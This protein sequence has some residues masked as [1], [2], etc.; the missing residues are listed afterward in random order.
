MSFSGEFHAY[1]KTLFLQRKEVP[2]LE[3]LITQSF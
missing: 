1:Q 3:L 2:S